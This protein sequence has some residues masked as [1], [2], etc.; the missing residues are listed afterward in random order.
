[1]IT[2]RLLKDL[3]GFVMLIFVVLGSYLRI[4]ALWYQYFAFKGSVWLNRVTAVKHLVK[5]ATHSDQNMVEC[6]GFILLLL[7]VMLTRSQ[8]DVSFFILS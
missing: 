8:L 2:E 4:N 7:N 1:M 5:I 3:D 6:C